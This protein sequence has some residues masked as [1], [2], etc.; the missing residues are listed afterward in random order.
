M[1]Y[2]KRYWMKYTASVHHTPIIPG[3]PYNGEFILL[4]GPGMACVCLCVT[5]M[6]FQHWQY[7]TQDG[8]KE[9]MRRIM[10]RDPSSS[11]CEHTWWDRV[12]ILAHCLHFLTALKRRFSAHCPVCGLQ[13]AYLSP[14]L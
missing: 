4:L 9:T 14:M 11:Y 3:A 6:R 8:R 12:T 7:F 1:V 10:H 13:I 5:L 2:D